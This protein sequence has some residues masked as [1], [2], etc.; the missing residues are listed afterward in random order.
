VKVLDFGLAKQVTTSEGDSDPEAQ[1]LLNTQ[2]REGVVVGTPMYLSPEQAMG[3][4]VDA[5]SDLFGL[6]SL[7]YECIAGTPAFTGSSTVEI[8]AKVIRDDAPPPSHFNSD[9]PAKLDRLTLK[10]LAKKPE[11]RH[12]SAD[13]VIAELRSVQQQLQSQSAA[14][15][16]TKRLSPHVPSTRGRSTISDIFTRPRFSIGYTI[17]GTLMLLLIA[18]GGWRF[19]KPKAHVPSGEAQRLYDL[20]VNALREGTYYKASKLLSKAVEEDDQ[21]TLAHARL[22]EVWAELDYS[23]RAKDELLRV[24]TLSKSHPLEPA[25]DVYVQ[26]ITLKLTG[27][28]GSAIEKFEEI[29]SQAGSEDKAAAYVDLGRAH[30]RD[31]NSKKARENYFSAHQIDPR[32]TP[33]SM[34]LAVLDG[35][36]L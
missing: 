32:S 21:F 35:R 28:S 8:C 11:D 5:R 17:V 22:A 23:D 30:E 19:L 13:E 34:R 26:A 14:Q 16:L 12:Q 9:I 18:W 15:R 27:N 29:L 25:D 31:G 10:A 2:T 1:T 7:L 20:G 36:Q 24:N 3:L 4:P 6:G 33:A